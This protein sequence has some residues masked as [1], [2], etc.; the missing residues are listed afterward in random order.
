MKRNKPVSKYAKGD[1]V[2]VPGFEISEVLIISEPPEWNGL[3][4]MYSFENEEMSCGEEYLRPAPATT[5]PQDNE[6]EQ[7][8]FALTQDGQTLNFEGD[9]ESCL[10]GYNSSKEPDETETFF[11]W[12]KNS[13]PYTNEKGESPIENGNLSPNSGEAAAPELFTGGEMKAVA[14]GETITISNFEG[15]T[16]RINPGGNYEAGIPSREDW[17][18]AKAVVSTLNHA[19][20]LLKENE[21]LQ[22]ALRRVISEVPLEDE[23]IWQDSEQARMM[24]DLSTAIKAI[25]NRVQK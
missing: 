25:L 23:S 9:K 8:I 20:A 10:N 21:E 4:W 18:L 13:Y 11:D 2:L 22:E 14:W 3:T 6:R 19:P 16:L 1:K 7:K 5:P 15:D 17:G 24:T 12:C